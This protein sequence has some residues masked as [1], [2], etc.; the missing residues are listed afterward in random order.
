MAVTEVSRPP[1][2]DR[3][4]TFR[5]VLCLACSLPASMAASHVGASS[6]NK[7]GTSGTRKHEDRRTNK[8][9]AASAL[10]VP[11]DHL[12][13]ANAIASPSRGRRSTRD[14]A[15]RDWPSTALA[16]ARADAP[17]Q[18]GARHRRASAPSIERYASHGLSDVHIGSTCCGSHGW[19]SP[20]DN[21]QAPHRSDARES[22][23]HTRH[24]CMASRGR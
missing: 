22:V 15:T 9:W 17:P 12:R 7:V 11:S 2:T 19:C 14:D 4:F 5:V 20:S 23:I 10:P 8:C 6:D 24:G 13:D 18:H 16:C 3:H 21:K 1:P